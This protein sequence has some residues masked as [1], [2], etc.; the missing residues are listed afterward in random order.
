MLLSAALAGACGTSADRRAGAPITVVAATAGAAAGVE[1]A[2][3]DRA[4]VRWLAR[5]APNDS[6]WARLVGVYVDRDRSH[7]AHAEASIELNTPAVIGR[8]SAD[9]DRVRFQPRFPFAAGV[10]YRVRVDTA[11]LRLLAERSTVTHDQTVTVPLVY[12]FSS[13]AVARAR[14]TRVVAVHPSATRLPSNLLRWYVEFSAPMEP[15][16]ALAHV[17]L[18]DES[19][20]EVRGAFLSLD[21]EL[22][23]PERRRLTLLF[24]PGRVKR[25]VR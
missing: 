9:G 3:V 21:Q 4:A 6:T 10:S 15:G 2:G 23:D 11:A 12:H 24:D 17:R 7:T 1:V 18:L 8:Y 22:W 14:T 20:R 5:L 19:G 25:G 13:V 16:S